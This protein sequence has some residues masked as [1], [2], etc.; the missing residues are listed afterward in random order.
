M[1]TNQCLYTASNY[2]DAETS[3][4]MF[5]IASQQTDKKPSAIRIIMI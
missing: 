1:M 4:L 2:L 3:A 5:F